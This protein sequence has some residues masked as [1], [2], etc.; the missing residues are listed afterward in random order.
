MVCAGGAAPKS[1]ERAP[2]RPGAAR[3][4][5]RPEPAPAP[6]R[7]SGARSAA[8]LGGAAETAS[9][10]FLSGP[11][12]GRGPLVRSAAGGEGRPRTAAPRRLGPAADEGP[13]RGRGPGGAAGLGAGAVRHP[14]RGRKRFVSN[15]AGA[16]EPG[17]T[18]SWFW[19]RFFLPLGCVGFVIN[20]AW[21]S[22]GNPR[23]GVACI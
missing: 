2:A 1:R 22:G 7:H 6:R 14:A 12:A 11:D 16:T 19:R 9:F 15:R 5:A 21:K 4:F 17:P 20:A 23:S 18:S 8:G 3:T 13:R 10:P